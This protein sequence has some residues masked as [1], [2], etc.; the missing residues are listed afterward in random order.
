MG[1]TK[2]K[3]ARTSKKSSTLKKVSGSKSFKNLE[4]NKL[5]ILDATVEY[6]FSDL[7]DGGKSEVPTKV[8]IDFLVNGIRCSIFVLPKLFLGDLGTEITLASGNQKVTSNCSIMTI[9][10]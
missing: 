3:L 6:G 10:E 7:Y 1:Q 8:S 2:K 9:E 5:E 4:K